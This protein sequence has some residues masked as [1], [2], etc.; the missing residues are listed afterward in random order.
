[1]GLGSRRTPGVPGSYDLIFNVGSEFDKQASQQKV[2]LS[3]LASASLDGDSLYSVTINVAGGSPI[4]S[5]LKKV[6]SGI[7]NVAG[8]DFHP[9]TGDFYFADNAMDHFQGQEDPFQADELNFISA[10]T[11]GAVVPDFGHPTCYTQ[12][13]TG[14]QI[15][16]GCT[17]PLAAFQPIP[18]DSNTAQSEGP[19][20]IAFAPKNFPAGFNNGIF[21]AFAGKGATGPTNEENALVYFDLGTGEYVHFVKSGLPGMARPIGLL[22]TSNSL[23]VADWTAGNIYQITSTVPE[24]GTAA[25]VVGA[26]LAGALFRRLRVLR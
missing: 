16:G 17:S 24:P 21:V 4:A 8:M 19:V 15:G 20:E 25:L 10:E 11:L 18:P 13:R 9:V 26:V 2:G 7:R 1:M 23:F 12:Y 22:A 3:G 5:D 14:A 6:A